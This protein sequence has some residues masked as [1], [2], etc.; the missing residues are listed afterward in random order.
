MPGTSTIPTVHDLLVQ[1]FTGAPGMA[2]VAAANGLQQIDVID[3]P[4][5]PGTSSQ[6]AIWVGWSPNPLVTAGVEV[7]STLADLGGVRDREQYTIHCCAAYVDGNSNMSN[8][9]TQAFAIAAA[10]RATI[11]VNRTLGGQQLLATFGAGTIT[12]T[13]MKTGSK[14]TVEF[15]VDVDSFTT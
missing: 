7:K 4:S 11:A 5:P 1:L 9:R 6:A 10:A 3:G 2:A 12:E 13:A 8:A 14:V 15:D